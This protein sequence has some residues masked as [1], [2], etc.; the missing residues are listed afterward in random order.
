M[1]E[2]LIMASNVYLFCSSE[3]KLIISGYLDETEIHIFW[4]L[5]N[6]KI[7]IKFEELTEKSNANPAHV[8]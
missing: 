3:K 6:S 4:L 1:K 5:G 7:C 8:G 2:A